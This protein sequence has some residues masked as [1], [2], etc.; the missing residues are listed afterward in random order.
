[1]P[2]A[3]RRDNSFQKGGAPT[4]LAIPA[5]SR[6]RWNATSVAIQPNF[7]PECGLM[8]AERSLPEHLITVHDYLTLS[9]TLLPRSVALTCLW[10][11]VLLTGD[12]QAHE[13]LCLL[14]GNQPDARGRIP[15]V[16]ALEAELLR[17]L[18]GGSSKK[19]REIERLVRNLRKSQAA[20]VYYWDL[21]TVPEARLRHLGREL[22]LPEVGQAL[23]DDQVTAAEVRRWLDKLCPMEDV[24]DKLRICQRL[25]HF[26]AAVAP[27][28]E[29]LRQLQEE[30]P[31][32][33]PNC[34][35]A[36]PQ[37]QIE[38]HLRKVHRVYQFQG[39]ARSLPE[40]ID[41][42]MAA[43]CSE[44]PNPEDWETLEA[45]AYD[46]FGAD[47]ETFLASRLAGSLKTMDA[48]SRRDTVTALGEIVAGSEAG[49]HLCEHLA[50]VPGRCV[51]QLVL[52]T[53]T[54]LPQPLPMSLVR[55]IRPLLIRKRAPARMQIAAA[56]ALVT[57]LGMEGR[58]LEKL[59]GTLI[60]RCHKVRALERLHRLE[61]ECG[62]LDAITDLC[63]SI[64][65][66]IRLSCPRCGVELLRPE[67]ARHLWEE[68]SL[69]LDGRTAKKPWQVVKDR[70]KEYRRRGDAELLTQCRALG[71]QLDP[72]NGL[73][74]VHRL[75]LAYHVDDLEARQVLLAGARQRNASLCPHCYALVGMPDETL[76]RPLNQSRGRLSLAGYCVEV[77]EAGLSPRLWIED[78]REV[79]YRGRE[80]NRWLSPR[81]ATLLVAGPLVLAALALAL[82]LPY[83]EISPRL[84]VASALL[85][86]LLA[87]VVVQLRMWSSPRPL[88][89]AIDYAWTWL[90]P[91]L[92][93]G[94]FSIEDSTFVA[95]LAMI[96]MKHGA[97]GARAGALERILR[98][99]ENAAAGSAAPISHL[100]MLKRLEIA[101]RAAAGH[102]PVLEVAAAL[103][104]CFEGKQPVIFVQQ[105]LADWEAVWWSPANLTRLRILLC[106]R[107]FEEGLEVTDLLAAGRAAPALGNVLQTENPNALAQLRLL[108]S[109]R[110]SQP[111]NRWS[112]A[113]MVFSL[114]KDANVGS[115]LL[116][117]YPDL[118]LIDHATP[119]V[120]LCGRGLIFQENLF[121]Q[122]PR[123]V[124]MKAR[125]EVNHVHY[126]VILND[127]HFPWLSDPTDLVHR[128]EQWFRFFFH[129]FV[130]LV[131]GVFSWRSPTGTRP[132]RS[133]QA[134]PCTDC[135]HMV[136]PIA[137]E[138]GVLVD[139]LKKPRN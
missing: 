104:R 118:L 122:P 32:A 24:W 2:D 82:G 15:Y 80:P 28:K 136:V 20:R 81:G 103:A 116:E 119:A 43:L 3:A 6:P 107:A 100:A 25:P 45:L 36:V 111:W 74:R 37:S 96:S 90:V 53:V 13:R 73:Q 121:T 106:D 105:L 48:R 8:V 61:E 33:C 49:T 51:R 112:N 67:M 35:L 128:L 76:P 130:P 94:D 34:G 29:C 88:H 1:M 68:H 46:E 64:E 58:N 98:L 72:D 131:H 97:A 137:G 19:K 21:L 91:R 109:L 113:V 75:V 56:A 139:S 114:A 22:L 66:Q 42:V 11:R 23:A 26:G 57:T 38:T 83:F 27:V 125:K 60:A 71:Q 44:R 50:G 63:T 93:A 124:E 129:D 108:W 47:A 138:V 87:S 110:P 10:D 132:L 77:R 135:Y 9:G 41:A 134:V 127:Y 30:R 85:L 86:A 62:T 40:T 123:R 39:V 5:A 4:Q 17:W 78:P 95:G 12:P 16:A 65:N 102:D 54:R 7:C 126:E 31:V 99:T 115:S 69:L 84:P 14:L 70:I 117:K 133:R 55:A 52:T 18:F 101:D 89:R 79:I 59:L 92:H 120:D